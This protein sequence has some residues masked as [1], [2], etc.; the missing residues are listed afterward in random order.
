M[1]KYV[2]VSA[3]SLLATLTQICEKVTNAGGTCNQGQ[4]GREITFDIAPP[5]TTVFLRVFTSLGAGDQSVRGCGKDAVRLV[6]GAN[7]GDKYKPLAPSRRIYRTAPQ[8]DHEGR[9]QAFLDRL[10][11]ALREG[12]KQAATHPICRVC[13]NPFSLRE[14]TKNKSKFWGCTG[15]PECKR[16]F[17]YVES[18]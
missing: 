16:T 5:D 13:E 6:V 1:S 12:Y 2:E 18:E 17:N 7:V 11:Q 4:S 8:G 10:T 3:E 14:N 15:Y 9:V